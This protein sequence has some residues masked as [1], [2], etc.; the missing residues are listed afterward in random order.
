LDCDRWARQVPAC[1]AEA[2]SRAGAGGS[3]VRSDLRLL[4]A[5]GREV[6]DS[7]ARG[8]A[9]H[10]QPDTIRVDVIR[11]KGEQYVSDLVADSHRRDL[12]RSSLRVDPGVR[13]THRLPDVGTAADDHQGLR[14][15]IG[16][17]LRVA[18]SRPA[19]AQSVS[20]GLSL[21]FLAW[22]LGSLGIWKLGMIPR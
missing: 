11:L 22:F 17:A 12:C 10:G 3:A 18:W 1:A 6:S 7:A 14:G 20:V 16:I 4:H 8:V 21:I 19:V 13:G 5:A 9:A 2:V 15:W